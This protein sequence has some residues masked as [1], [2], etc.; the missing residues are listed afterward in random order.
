M[1]IGVSLI[2]KCRGKPRKTK[3]ETIKKDLELND[4]PEDMGY[5]RTEWC[6]LIYAP[7]PT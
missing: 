1:E 5:D 2:I 4:I 7:D 6:R 3:E